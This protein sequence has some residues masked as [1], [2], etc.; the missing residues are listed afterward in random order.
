L[1]KILVLV[2]AAM[3]AGSA[4]TGAAVARDRAELS[5]NQIVDQIS[6]NTARIKAELRLTPEQEKNWGGFESA[7]TSM[8]KTNA[9]R[10]IA[11]RDERA[12]QKGPIDIIGQLRL[13]A[14]YLGERSV[15]RKTL[16]D[17]AEPLYAS[18]NDQQKQRF[19]KELEGISRGPD[20]DD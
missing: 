12:Q 8:G 7:M 16:A 6:A 3:L 18:L 17:A 20:D 10:E 14:R 15:D 5:V 13:Q 11:R 4:L 2:T 1:R 9:E 19:A